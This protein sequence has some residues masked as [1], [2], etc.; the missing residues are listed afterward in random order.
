MKL[1]MRINLGLEN[2]KTP[3]ISDSENNEKHPKNKKAI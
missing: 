1:K 3:N 2:P